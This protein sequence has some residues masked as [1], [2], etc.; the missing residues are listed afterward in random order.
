M[1]DL[2]RKQVLVFI[3]DLIVFSKTLEE[4]ESRLIQVLN[5]HKK[6]LLKLSPEKMPFHSDVSQIHLGHVVSGDGVKTDPAKI[7]ALKT[8]PR[9]T[10]LKELRA[11]LGFAGY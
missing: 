1:G 9:P 7:E 6:Y 8:W 2:H 11:F 5:Q 3:D 10:N 4:H